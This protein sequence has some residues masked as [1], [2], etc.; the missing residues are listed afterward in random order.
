MQSIYHLPFIVGTPG[1]E[2]STLQVPIM[3][4][5]HWATGWRTYAV[6][7]EQNPNPDIRQ[8]TNSGFLRMFI[9]HKYFF[10]YLF[11]GGRK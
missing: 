6:G 3:Y 7:V 10:N 5:S 11:L 1:L 4:L 8:S 2:S 9:L